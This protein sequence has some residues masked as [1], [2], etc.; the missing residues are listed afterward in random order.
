M[1]N[2]YS[3]R[4]QQ[5]MDFDELR[6]YSKTLEVLLESKLKK[7]NQLV[8]R[9]AKKVSIEELEDFYTDHY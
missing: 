2:L 7:F 1:D 6:D 5:G 3:F 4:H 9:R 8:E